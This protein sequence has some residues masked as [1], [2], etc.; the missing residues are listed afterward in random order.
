M[1]SPLLGPRWLGIHLLVVLLAAVCVAGTAWQFARA[2]EPDRT[3][4]TNPAEDLADAVPIG[5]LLEPGQYMHPE[6][7]ANTAV[8]ATG[9]YDAD[10]QLL[11][12]ASEEG[13]RG[14]H[15]ILP[16]VTGDG[17]AVTVNRGWAEEGQEIPPVT[18]EEVTVS[19]WLQP[20]VADGGYTPVSPPEGQVERIATSLLVNKWDHPLYE[21]YVALPEQ[22]PATDSLV[23]DEPPRPPTGITVNWRSLSYTLQWAMFGVSGVVFWIILMR[24][25]LADAREQEEGAPSEPEETPV[26]KGD[27]AAAADS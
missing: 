14:Y 13:V 8:T 25:E 4:I 27:Q 20:P 17:A 26:P 6:T 12:P 15:V 3:V 23:P 18:D 22:D 11:V 7:H 21:G 24:R 10:S 9:H 16:L 5:E 19:G 1:R 2:F